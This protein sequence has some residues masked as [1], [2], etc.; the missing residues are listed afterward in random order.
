MYAC[1]HVC[2]YVC[3]CIYVR[4]YVCI[5]IYIY[6]YICTHEGIKVSE[7]EQTSKT[8]VKTPLAC[9]SYRCPQLSMR[10][11]R[12]AV[13]TTRWP[14]MENS[15]DS[16]RIPH[17][18]IYIYIYIHIKFIYTHQVH[19]YIYIYIYT[20][21]YI[22]IQATGTILAQK[23]CLLPLLNR[24]A[25]TLARLSRCSCGKRRY[26]SGHLRV[27]DT[28]DRRRVPSGTYGSPIRYIHIHAHTL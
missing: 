15:A 2:M 20:H 14:W 19:R 8:H 26:E 27:A 12:A 18:Y 16:L 10:T 1:V 3:V 21:I 24:A 4:M 5:Y 17:I 11:L 9:L 28:G 6:I 23:L 13:V 22:L 7:T 25:R